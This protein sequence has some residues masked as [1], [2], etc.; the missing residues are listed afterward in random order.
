M[1]DKKILKPFFR[2]LKNLNVYENYKNNIVDLNHKLL[3]YHF[4][5]FDKV[6]NYELLNLTLRWKM[7]LEGYNFWYNVYHKM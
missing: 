6:S 4:N 5:D 2:E 3:D 7:T 1:K